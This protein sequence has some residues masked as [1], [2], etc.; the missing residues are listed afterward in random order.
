M[1]LYETMREILQRKM[2]GILGEE[3][4]FH[5][6]TDTPKLKGFAEKMAGKNIR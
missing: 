3:Q 4:N 5:S 1:K 6:H 2:D